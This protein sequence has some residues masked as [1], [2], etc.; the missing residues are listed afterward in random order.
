M[1]INLDL[2][3]LGAFI[4]RIA[5]TTYY[6]HIR[7]CGPDSPDGPLLLC[8]NHNN[9]FIDCAFSNE[10]HNRFGHCTYAEASRSNFVLKLLLDSIRGIPIKRPFDF[11]FQGT[12]NIT[13]EGTTIR[14]QGTNFLQEVKPGDRIACGRNTNKIISIT[15][16]TLMTVET[17]DFRTYFNESFTI[18]PKLEQRIAFNNV[19][20]ALIAHRAVLIHPEGQPHDNPFLIK[21]QAGVANI[22]LETLERTPDTLYLHAIGLNY[23][24]QDEFRTDVIICRGEAFEVPQEIFKLWTEGQKTEAIRALLEL[25]TDEMNKTLIKA[26]SI[27]EHSSVKI[28]HSILLDNQPSL[29]SEEIM[30]MGRTAEKMYP[31][32]D[33][34]TLLDSYRDRIAR[35]GLKDSDVKALGQSRCMSHFMLSVISLILVLPFY[36]S[37]LFAYGPVIAVAQCIVNRKK[38]TMLRNPLRV[39]G[40]DFPASYIILSIKLLTPIFLSILSIISASYMMYHEYSLLTIVQLQVTFCLVY[41]F[42]FYYVWLHCHDAFW[43][44]IKAIRLIS[45]GNARQLLAMRGEIR[46]SLTIKS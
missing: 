41:A 26:G 7:V 21:L 36:L 40:K 34:K 18:E 9:L 5:I 33:K 27:A 25:I 45:C 42:Y 38:R 20:E 29:T 3:W 11:R 32:M 46:A 13:R 16:D 28:L 1:K 35:I 30:E 23:S 39:E 15:S 12:G 31:D 24:D 19:I 14:G 4:V 6:R 17:D 10:F 2:S 37:G 8:L 43:D 22:A 44:S